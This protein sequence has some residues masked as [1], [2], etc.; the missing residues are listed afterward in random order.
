MRCLYRR[1][2]RTARRIRES[3]NASNSANRT[4]CKVRR[5]QA[6]A[7]RRFDLLPKIAAQ[8]ACEFILAPLEASAR[9]KMPTSMFSTL[10]T[11]SFSHLD[12]GDGS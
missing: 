10:T 2:S 1:S 5:K 3:C 11:T 9:S 6:T 8:F 7:F 4:A 12:N